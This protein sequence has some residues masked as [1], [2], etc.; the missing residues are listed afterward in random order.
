MNHSILYLGLDVHLQCIRIAIINAAGKLVN[1]R[2]IET[3][4]QA[5]RDVLHSLP[6][7]LHVTFEESTHAA[8]LYDVVRPLVQQVVVC[9]PKHHR[10][11]LSGSKRDRI[12]AR[13]LAEWLRLGALQPV[14]HGEHG[15]RTLKQLLRSLECFVLDITRVKNRLPALYNRLAIGSR[16]RELYHTSKRQSWIERVEEPGRRLRAT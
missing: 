5:V 1:Q 2:V 11:L 4:T 14:S 15:T 12:D 9:N 3:S 7:Q 10:L 8:W 6:G 13:K 16:G